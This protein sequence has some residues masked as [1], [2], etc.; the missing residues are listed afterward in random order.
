VDL[1]WAE[2]QRR[3]QGSCAGAPTDSDDKVCVTGSCS[4]F[5]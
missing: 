2:V 5:D 3:R 1:H 4:D